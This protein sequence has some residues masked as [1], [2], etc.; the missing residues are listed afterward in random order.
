MEESKSAMLF[1]LK[2]DIKAIESDKIGAIMKANKEKMKNNLGN[3]LANSKEK[4]FNRMK[5]RQ[6]F[7]KKAESFHKPKEANK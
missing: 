3:L 5:M 4:T 2:P 1:K 7:L 6:N